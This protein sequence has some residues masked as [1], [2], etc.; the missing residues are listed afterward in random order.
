[1]SADILNSAA[2]VRIAKNKHKSFVLLNWC[3]PDNIP[4]WG[5]TKAHARSMLNEGKI[6]CARTLLESHSGKGIYLVH[7]EQELDRIVQEKNVKLFVEYIKKKYE[8]RVHVLPDGTTHTV[9]K[10]RRIDTPNEAVDWR[11]RSYHNGFVFCNEMEYKPEGIEHFAKLAVKTLGLDF[12]A[13]DIIYNAHQDKCYV[14]EVNCAPS[15]RGDTTIGK[16]VQAF[17]NKINM[18]RE[19]RRPH[20]EDTNTSLWHLAA[21]GVE[22]SVTAAQRERDTVYWQSAAG[23]QS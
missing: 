14:L 23:L 15:L 12:G 10:R 20:N 8:Y 16:Y 1:M 17:N 7:N 13:C 3:I 6:V 5:L 21:S 9:Q 4:T 2:A 11:I 18:I 22:S 19:E